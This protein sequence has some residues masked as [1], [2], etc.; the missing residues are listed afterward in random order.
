MFKPLGPSTNHGLDHSVRLGV[1]TD[2]GVPPMFALLDPI[3]LAGELSALR[4]SLDSL[5]G[6]F[7][8]R[9]RTDPE[10]AERT[11]QISAAIQRLE[12]ALARHQRA[13]MCAGSGN[14]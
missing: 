14:R 10:V 5:A 13:S 7:R 9:Y 8:D 3:A 12:W 2:M 6:R 1:S 4:T 11:E